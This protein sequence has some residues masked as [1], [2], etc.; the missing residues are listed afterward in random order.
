MKQIIDAY[1]AISV[2]EAPLDAQAYAVCAKNAQHKKSIRVGHILIAACLAIVLMGG[3]AI[4]LSPDLREYAISFFKS[5][6]IETPVFK[7]D[8]PVSAPA[9]EAASTPVDTLPPSE[10][11]PNT[12]DI[13][14]EPRG[15]FLGQQDIDGIARVRYFKFDHGFDIFHNTI[16]IYN[17][18]GSCEIYGLLGNDLTA[19]EQYHIDDVMHINGYS[20]PLSFT[21]VIDDGVIRTFDNVYDRESGG[22]AAALG[23][24][25]SEFVW[26]RFSIRYE[27]NTLLQYNLRTGEYRDVISEAGVK[28][29]GDS[30]GYT[31]VWLS[32]DET[33]ILVNDWDAVYLINA[34]T[35][36]TRVLTEI[37]NLI[38]PDSSVTP[39]GSDLSIG[40]IDN[41]TLSVWQ[42]T[43]HDVVR[44]SVYWYDIESG[45]LT[46]VVEDTPYYSP[47]ANQLTGV[48]GLGLGF[49]LLVEP[50]HYIL[51]ND[52]SGDRYT[53]EG[54]APH[55]DIHFSLSPDRKFI[56][57]TTM[58]N[59]N[60]FGITQLGYINIEKQE[61]KIFDRMDFTDIFEWMM[62]WISDNELA[63]FA[64][65]DEDQ[66]QYQYLY[67]YQ[68]E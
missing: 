48:S 1:N 28:I 67:I 26:V 45:V 15:Y 43:G 41:N 44:F 59:V 25:N 20:I 24:Y 40:F 23:S 54:L 10:S 7:T 50:D 62:G 68:F 61:L 55:P 60:G 32:P 57:V 46:S 19:L 11:Y 49:T 34:E 63:V 53:I 58:S 13:T 38:N 5:E 17:E 29:S 21:Y 30:H 8:A 64:R 52:I 37:I 9:P 33:A 14:E 42:H 56:S 35:M 6:Q 3:T 4:A 36:Q 22:E 16:I 65:D 31:E 18:D 39:D 27:Y 47:N 51:I 66:Y 2:P 12:G